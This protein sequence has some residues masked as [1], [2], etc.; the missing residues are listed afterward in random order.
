MSEGGLH[1]VFGTGQV[2]LALADRLAGLGAEV[3]AVSRR[4]P[5][6]LPDSVDWRGADATDL[7]AAADAANGASV[8]YQ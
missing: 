8:V 4:R 6:A 2:G 5:A 3:R 7:D 1:V